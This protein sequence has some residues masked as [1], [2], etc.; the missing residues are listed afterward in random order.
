MDAMTTSRIPHQREKDSE[1]PDSP[2]ATGKIK[3]ITNTI[4][5]AIASWR[6]L[7]VDVM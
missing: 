6:F 1:F 5:V 3:E 7:R 2:A 4:A